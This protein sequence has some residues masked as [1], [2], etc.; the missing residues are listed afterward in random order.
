ME[1]IATDLLEQYIIGKDQD[2]YKILETIYDKKA[3]VEF[4]INSDTINFPGKINGNALIAKTLS[5]DFNLTYE[6]VRTY[7][8]SKE[9]SD[10][11]NIKEQPWLVVMK[12]IGRDLTR[13]GTGYYNWKFTGHNSDLKIIKH[14]IYIHT[15]LEIHDPRSMQLEEIQTLLEYPWAERKAV[16]KILKG[17]ENLKEITEY[18]RF[19]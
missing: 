16:V 17:Y 1:T 14:K 11:K 2:K 13:I 3:E 4:E 8:L 9:I 12:E 18:L 19:R 15:M 6:K 5:A 7:Y 10:A